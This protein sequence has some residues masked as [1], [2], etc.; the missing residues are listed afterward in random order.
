MATIP[1]VAAI[2]VEAGAALEEA[3]IPVAE[4]AYHLIGVSI[5]AL[6]EDALNVP[7]ASLASMAITLKPVPN[8]IQ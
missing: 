7:E 3:A 2:P 6:P 5:T 4:A 8:A 1:A